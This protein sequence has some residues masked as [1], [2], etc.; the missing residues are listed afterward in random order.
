MTSQAAENWHKVTLVSLSR[1]PHPHP[2]HL[3]SIFFVGRSTE[4]SQLTIA[5][6]WTNLILKIRTTFSQVPASSRDFRHRRLRGALQLWFTFRANS[7]EAKWLNYTFKYNFIKHQDESI[8]RGLILRVS[9][10]QKRAFL[11]FTSL[12]SFHFFSFFFFYCM[13]TWV[14]SVHIASLTCSPMGQWEDLP[15]TNAK[16]Q[17]SEWFHYSWCSLPSVFYGEAK[18]SVQ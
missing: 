6:S 7:T 5:L 3:A 1:A 15:R 12:R 2:H 17:L 16:W 9:V 4:S 18:G 14:G 13:C 8:C 10:W 11:C